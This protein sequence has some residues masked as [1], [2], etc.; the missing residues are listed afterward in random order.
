MQPSRH[1][2]VVGVGVLVAFGNMPS[3]VSEP[4]PSQSPSAAK[5]DELLPFSLQEATASVEAIPLNKSKTVL[6]RTVPTEPIA[7]TAITPEFSQQKGFS[8][9]QQ[10]V[11]IEG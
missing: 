1:L 5:T 4:L 6:S 3:G 11:K 2:I 8:H 9:S 10:T 7:L